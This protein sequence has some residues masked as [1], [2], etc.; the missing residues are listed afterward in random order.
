MQVLIV[1]RV[2][3]NQSEI[4]QGFA[5]REF[6]INVQTLTDQVIPIQVRGCDSVR[7]LRQ[8]VSS[9]SNFRGSSVDALAHMR[10]LAPAFA[11]VDFAT[12]NSPSSWYVEFESSS[13]S[14][15]LVHARAQVTRK[16]PPF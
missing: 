13:N 5:P 2:P 10:L 1:T 16:D 3:G 9:F 14:S 8:K 12:A 6:R 11:G 7:S 15:R 4:E